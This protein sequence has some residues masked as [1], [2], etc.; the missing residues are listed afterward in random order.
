VTELD[1]TIATNQRKKDRNVNII[2]T[3]I[4]ILCGLMVV[5]PIFWMIRTS[6]M[7]NIEI[8]QYPPKLL[9]KNLLFSNYTDALTTFAFGR[10]LFNTLTIVV[11][12]IIGVLLTSSIAAYAFARLEFPLKNLWFTLIIG[13]MLM[14]A[15]VTLIPIFIVWSKLGF[16]NSYVPLIVPAYLGGGAFNIFLIRQFMLTI[17]KDLD[18]AAIIDGASHMQILF[19]ILI[20]MVK[21]VLISVG[22]FTFIN[23]WNDLLGPVIYISDQDKSTIAQ[24]LATFKGGFGTN[25]RVLM[26]AS[27]MSTIPAAL[28]YVFGQKY[29]IEGIVLT[30]LKS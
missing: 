7:T 26:A 25:W 9:P 23:L 6:F 16:Y 29:F 22:L 15:A 1:K 3:V 24:G 2:V 17:P 19:Q 10:Y 5:F 28:I 4:I 14:P 20:P 27:C 12:S 18:E 13:S 8:N 11:S 30:G 21:P